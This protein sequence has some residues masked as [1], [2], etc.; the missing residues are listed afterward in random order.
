MRT[1]IKGGWVVGFSGHTHTLIRDGVVVFE[2][3]KI[4]YV[5]TKFSGS[6]DHK[7]DASGKLV[8]PGFIDTHVH[9]GHRASH[10]LICDVGRP[11]YFG[12]PFLEISVPR[13]GTRVSGDPRYFRPNEQD[14]DV[15]TQLQAK[16]TVSE[17]LRNGI[18]TFVEFGS[19]LHVQRALVR[20]V[21]AQGIRAYLGP[22]YDSGRWVG[23]K[24]GCLKRVVNE[25]S[26]QRELEEAVEFIKQFHQSCSGRLHGILVPREVETCSLSLLRQTKKWATELDVPIATHAAYSVLEFYEIVKTHQMTPIELLDSLELLDPKLNIGHGNFV[27]ENPLMNYSGGRDLELM[28]KGGVSISHCPVNLVRRGRYLDSW[29]RYC[30]A[31]INIALGSDTYPRDLIMQMR[32]ASYFGKVIGHNLKAASA[33][34][35][36]QAAT[37][38]GAYSLGRADL[39]RL[40]PGAKADI[41]IIDLSGRN[42]LR[43][44]PIRDP[45]KSLVECGIGD[46]VETVI[47]DGITRMHEGQ[48]PGVCLFELRREAQNAG[49]SVWAELPQWHSQGK[50]AE[51]MSP[52]SFPLMN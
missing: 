2:D 29:E 3:E 45:I 46:D 27:A 38:G 13:Q 33:A 15:G 14:A 5:G 37:I 17:M 21:E 4:I 25:E 9:T 47:I 34:Q 1:I 50:T 7:I 35:V 10:R 41:I 18:T 16:F 43:Y 51:E 12:Q 28:G 52:W 24:N 20:E 31:G 40:C 6:F 11:D 19:Q 36:F 23:G 30:N 42:T 48:I 26:G 32:I 49:Y 8:S 22:G 39:G 44:G